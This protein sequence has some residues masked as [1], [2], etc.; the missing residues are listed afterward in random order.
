M[1]RNLQSDV[2]KLVINHIAEIENE[3]FDARGLRSFDFEID[4]YKKPD[5][6]L[7]YRASADVHDIV[8]T[9]QYTGEDY[10]YTEQT[11][12]YSLHIDGAEYYFNVEDEQGDIYTEEDFEEFNENN[13]YRITS[14][15]TI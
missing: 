1:D 5:D 10:Y 9:A 7:I 14:R 12:T 6:L 15:E 11:M 2:E 8:S 4:G 13:E 3:L